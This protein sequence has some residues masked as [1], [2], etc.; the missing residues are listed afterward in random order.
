MTERNPADGPLKD[1]ACCA[2]SRRHEE[3]RCQDA[4]R[5]DTDAQGMTDRDA[6]RKREVREE[7]LADEQRGA[8]TAM[9]GSRQ[10]GRQVVL[11][12]ADRNQRKVIERN[13][14]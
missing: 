5:C 9:P 11:D 1:T 7:A 3:V 14:Q 2:R 12:Q 6:D 13:A 4:V 10:C 8:V